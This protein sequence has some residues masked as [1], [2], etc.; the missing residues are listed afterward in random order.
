MPSPL[1]SDFVK[2]LKSAKASAGLNEAI[3]L[4]AL[5]HAGQTDKGGALYGQVR[6]LL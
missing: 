1:L 3:A 5:A 2:A 6:K 4:A